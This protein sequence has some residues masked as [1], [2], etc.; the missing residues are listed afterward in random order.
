M[1]RPKEKK[2]KKKCYPLIRGPLET[3]Q[4]YH[5]VL[6]EGGWAGRVS[7]DKQVVL[8][9]TLWCIFF[10]WWWPTLYFILMNFTSYLHSLHTLQEGKKSFFFS[11][12]HWEFTLMSKDLYMTV[13]EMSFCSLLVKRTIK[14]KPYWWHKVLLLHRTS[15]RG[16]ATE[17]MGR[18]PDMR[19]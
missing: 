7:K 6:S 5:R 15:R 12:C 17:W 19:L 18:G 11:I 16:T 1:V 9:L 4:Y 13:S 14:R 8:L 3:Q 10:F 2:K